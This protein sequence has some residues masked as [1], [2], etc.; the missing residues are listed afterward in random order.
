MMK[1]GLVGCG[2][3]YKKEAPYM[4]RTYSG[5]PISAKD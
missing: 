4:G 5:R 1:D 3:I 2:E